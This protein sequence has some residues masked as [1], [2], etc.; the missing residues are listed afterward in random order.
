MIFHSYQF[1]SWLVVWNS[2]YFSIYIGNVIIPTEFHIFQRGRSTT[3]QHLNIGLNMHCFKVSLWCPQDGLGSLPSFLPHLISN[4]PVPSRS[5]HMLNN[6]KD[7]SNI[8]LEA[9]LH[10]FDSMNSQMFSIYPRFSHLFA[11]F[12]QGRR[13]AWMPAKTWR[14]PPAAPRGASST[15]S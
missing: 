8:I 10:E 13:R 9:N 1:S 7:G 3:N 12:F 11:A 5:S 15:R 6:L 2:F 4:V 14:A